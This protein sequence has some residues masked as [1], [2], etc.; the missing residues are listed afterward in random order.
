MTLAN[1]LNL[2]FLHFLEK[3]QVIPK[4]KKKLEVLKIVL[5]FFFL[6]GN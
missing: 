1:H 3:Y 2:F 6:V 5:F 4:K